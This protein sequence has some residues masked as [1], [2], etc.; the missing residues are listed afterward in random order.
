VIEERIKGAENSKSTRVTDAK[1]AKVLKQWPHDFLSH[2]WVDCKEAA[3]GADGRAECGKRGTSW[4]PAVPLRLYRKSAT[5]RAV[6]RV[7]DVPTVLPSS[8]FNF[9]PGTSPSWSPK[10]CTLQYTAGDPLQ[11]PINKPLGLLL[12]FG[13]RS[14]PRRPQ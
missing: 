12:I 3:D 4:R 9:V 10:V 8:N 5:A 13:L 7:T 14:R 2:P 1:G 6:R 11:H